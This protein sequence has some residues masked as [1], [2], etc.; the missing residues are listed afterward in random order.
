MEY[1][2]TY[3]WA[4]LIISIV[5]A[6]LFALGI[7]S[8][9][10]FI[11]TACVAAS[12]YECA[13]PIMHTGVFS[14]IVGQATGNSWTVANVIFVI[15]GSTAPSGLAPSPTAS[16]DEQPSGGVLANGGTFTVT[17]NGAYY[18][19]ACYGWGTTQVPGGNTIGSTVVGSLWASYT[20]ASG[21]GL[22]SQIA[23]V[24]LKAT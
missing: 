22:Y 8:S 10:S 4:I 21:S 14:A 2:M 23:T 11:G 17:Y 9:S 3:G 6:A 24:T 15:A 7:F 18:N 12:G 16:C 20:T 13:N 19:G 1:L 5:L